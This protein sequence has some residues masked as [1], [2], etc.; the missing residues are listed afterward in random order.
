MRAVILAGG[1][2]TRL[3]PY[4]AILPKPLMP[5]GEQ[6]ILEIIIRQLKHYGF[7]RVTVALGHLSHLV[8]A[9]LGNGEQFGIEIDYSIEDAPLGT[10]GPLA[11]IPNLE[12]TFLV[13]NGDV[14][15]DLKLAEMLK[16]HRENKAV[17][18]IASHK[19]S[20]NINYG[21]IRRNGLRVTEYDEKPV[22]NYEVSM[23]V[24][25]FEPEV[26]KHINSGCYLDFPDLVRILV[27][28]GGAVLSYPY[29]GIWFDLGR[30][31][32]FQDVQEIYKDMA[33]TL[34]YLH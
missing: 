17:A 30:P 10:S 2:G 9:V 3:A 11:L 26:L 18:T 1:K 20:V 4:T 12:E 31:E 29:D 33:G 19:R 8:K 6:S 15:T 23:G 27:D 14:F 7:K 32:D 25:I 34:P 13:M 28:A 5:I 22:I 21:V 16:F 24:Y